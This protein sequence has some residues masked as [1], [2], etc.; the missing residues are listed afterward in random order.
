MLMETSPQP[1]PLIAGGGGGKS[2]S[3]S[4]PS[5]QAKACVLFLAQP[6]SRSFFRQDDDDSC[7]CVAHQ[8]EGWSDPA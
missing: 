8:P 4:R 2:V 5:A 3:P 1:H 6:L 7:A